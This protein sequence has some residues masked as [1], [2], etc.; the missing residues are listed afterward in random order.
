MIFV[1]L[2][3]IG[4]LIYPSNWREKYICS[5]VEGCKTLPTLTRLP[6]NTSKVRINKELSE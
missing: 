5:G 1:N 4:D 2:G 6:K 3:N